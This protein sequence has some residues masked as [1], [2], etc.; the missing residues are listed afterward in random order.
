MIHLPGLKPV[1]SVHVTWTTASHAM[2]IL[3]NV[4]DASAS[5]AGGE[6]IVILQV[7]H[8]L[9]YRFARNMNNLC[10]N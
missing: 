6:S 4:S 10:F 8:F 5:M 1:R 3:G 7:G 9:I 2:L